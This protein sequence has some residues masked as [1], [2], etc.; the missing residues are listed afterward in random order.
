[1]LIGTG[2]IASKFLGLKSELKAKMELVMLTK[3]PR[4]GKMLQI[5][6]SFESVPRCIL[7]V[8]TCFIYQDHSTYVPPLITK[9]FQ[10]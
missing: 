7:L 3:L 5:Q 6:Y 10:Q 8:C 4:L 2:D 1:M 9:Y